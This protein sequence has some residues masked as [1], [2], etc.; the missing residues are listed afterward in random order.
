MESIDRTQCGSNASSNT[1][2]GSTQLASE[3]RNRQSTGS[4]VDAIPDDLT[5]RSVLC[6]GAGDGTCCFEAVRRGASRVVGIDVRHDHIDAARRRAES[7]GM[8][9][10]FRQLD[11]DARY[12]EET[13]DDVICLTGLSQSV[14]PVVLLDRLVDSC[15]ER[16]IIGVERLNRSILKE[17]KLNWWRR[18]LFGAFTSTPI[19]FVSPNAPRRRRRRFYLST[20]A[21]RCILT[22]R[23]QVFSHV[24]TAHPSDRRYDVLI[25]YKRRIENLIVIAGPTS[26]GKTTLKNKLAS[27]Q[28]NELCK[29][30]G[31]GDI[32]CWQQMEFYD[33]INHPRAELPNV[34]MHYDFHAR[35]KWNLEHEQMFEFV[36]IVNSAR[37]LK[38]VTLWTAPDQLRKQFETSEI[39]DHIRRT[40]VAPKSG[41]T[42]RLREDYKDANKIVQYYRCWLDFASSFESKHY[43]LSNTDETRMMTVEQWES[44][45]SGGSLQSQP[46]DRVAE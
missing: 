37:N 41:K 42:L 18:L 16:L 19:A 26:A 20:E 23:R 29:E 13:F 9:V 5:G 38:I 25:G 21:V 39:Q 34:I 45:C 15:R 14:A 12:P 1:H 40:G 24:E 30:L 10:D 28:A 7:L 35:L 27:G 31:I 2:G 3:R 36:D 44:E 4:L 6:V 17:L 33:L 43:I 46:V 11:F 22:E 8:A 32:S